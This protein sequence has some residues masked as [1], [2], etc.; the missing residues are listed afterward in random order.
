MNSL[1]VAL[2]HDYL[3]QPGGAEKVFE[4]LAGMFPGAP[5][6]TSVYDPAGVP[7]VWR[8]R[9][10][11]TS[12]LQRISPR[13]RVAKAYLPL[14]PT[15]F[16]AFDLSDFDLV[17][18]ST[19]AFA[20]GVITRPATCHIC[21]CNNPSRFLW[22]YHDY[23]ALERLPLGG[24]VLLPWIMTPLRLWDFQA[25]QRVDCFVAGSYNAARRIEKYY[26]RDSDVLQP[27]V[28]TSQFF[29][30]DRHDDFFLVASRLQAYKRIDLA[31]EACSR[32]GLPLHVLGDGPDRPR[33]EQLAGPSVRFFGR[34][35]DSELRGQLARC[36]AFLFPGEEDFGLTPVEA[37]ASGRPVIAYAAGGALE[38]VRD[39]ATGTFFRPQTT[40]ALSETL[41]NF[42]DDFDPV[43][44]RRHAQSFDQTTFVQ[45]LFEL[46][47]RRY[48]EHV[49]RFGALT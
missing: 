25:A 9:D 48:G 6:Y 31:V 19:T 34:V 24:R 5:I 1:R 11:R 18:S 30:A 15:A 20:K 4:V 42:S 8:S 29:I 33:L 27:P 45:R 39:G 7:D 43:E 38:T 21:Y 28:D 32:L 10:V 3:N 36:R 49:A 16:E 14:Y 37:Q 22:A 12:F 17:L 40:E 44:I 41:R 46:I 13:M 47:A 35:S 23:V 2:V 26:R